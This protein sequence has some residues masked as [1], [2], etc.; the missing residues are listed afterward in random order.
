MKCI[1]IYL[2]AVG[3]N[4]RLFG[5]HF[6]KK[7]GLIPDLY[8]VKSKSDEIDYKIHKKLVEMS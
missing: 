1:R 7:H 8:K 6:C 3:A 4:R 5:H 2:P